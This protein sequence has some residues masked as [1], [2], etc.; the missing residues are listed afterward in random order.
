MFII[1]PP[2]LASSFQLERNFSKG[3]RF[4]RPVLTERYMHLAKVRNEMM[5]QI[6]VIIA[7]RYTL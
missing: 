6:L 4:S 2:S 3:V 7:V 1:P 5:T